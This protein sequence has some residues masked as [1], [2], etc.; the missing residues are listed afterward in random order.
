MWNLVSVIKG[1]FRWHNTSRRTMAV[2]STHPLREMSDRNIFWGKGG[3]CVRLTAWPPSHADC[4]EIWEPQTPGTITACL[5]L[6]RDC[7]TQ[8][9]KEQRIGVIEKREI[10]GDRR[11]LRNW[12]L[13]NFYSS[14]NIRGIKSRR[15][16]CAGHVARMGEL[17]TGF[18]WRNE[19]EE[20]TL[21]TWD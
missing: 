3:R 21:K 18:W 10:R 9:R 4:L 12:K 15:M 8:L 17:C 13:H 20:V 2:G 16:R 6:Y 7:F 14:A 19:R 11:K 1:I 5:G